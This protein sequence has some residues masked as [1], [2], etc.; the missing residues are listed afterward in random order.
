V[1]RLV[2]DA[3]RYGGALIINWHDRSLA[4]ER[5]WGQFYVQLID[6]LKHRGA[7]FPTRHAGCIVVLSTPLRG[8]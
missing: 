6:E 8:V 7:W 1:W 2:D 3:E 5:L 4:P